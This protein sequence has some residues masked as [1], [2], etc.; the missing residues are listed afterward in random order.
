MKATHPAQGRHAAR[1]PAPQPKPRNRAEPR[2]VEPGVREIMIARAA[3]YIAERRGFEPGGE[4]DDWLAAEHEIDRLLALLAGAGDG[5]EPE[6]A[7]AP[8]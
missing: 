8:D 7:R 1:Q 4:L 3:Y 6:G 5:D 2:P